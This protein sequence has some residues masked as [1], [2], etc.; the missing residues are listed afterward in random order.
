M[1]KIIST[2][3]TNRIKKT[4]DVLIKDNQTGFIPG[5]CITENVRLVYDIIFETKLQ[6]K[7]GLLILID[8]EK[9]FD[10]VSKNFIMKTLKRFGF[11]NNMLKWVTILI[12]N[13]SSCVIQNGHLSSLFENE[14]GCR[15]GDPISPY[16]FLFVAEVLRTMISDNVN[17]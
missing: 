10:T 16:L 12:S 7:K 8:F 14:G 15:Q 3:I 1:Y 2:C 17:V 9:A 6:N 5:R 11:G 13:A 4:L